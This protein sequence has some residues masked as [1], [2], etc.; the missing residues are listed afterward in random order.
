MA[1]GQWGRPMIQHEISFLTQEARVDSVESD[2]EAQW[3]MQQPA[4]DSILSRFRILAGQTYEQMLGAEQMAVGR[5]APRIRLE[6]DSDEIGPTGL[7]IRE[8]PLLTADSART[9]RGCSPH[10]RNTRRNV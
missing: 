10:G 7:Y 6:P 2:P 9:R 8:L 5:E 1:E 4:Q 3:K